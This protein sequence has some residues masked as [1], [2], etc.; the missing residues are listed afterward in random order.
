MEHKFC[1]TC[2]KELVSRFVFDHYDK[3]NGE[4]LY[5]QFFTCPSRRWWNFFLHDRYYATI[6][7]FG[8]SHPMHYTEKYIKLMKDS[9]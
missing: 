7:T 5:K 4:K 8:G 2:G 1:E 6:G 9:S 3:R